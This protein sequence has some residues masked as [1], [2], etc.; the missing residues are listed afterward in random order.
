MQ[1]TNR[2]I[3]VPGIALFGVII[4]VVVSSMVRVVPP[5]RY[6]VLLPL[7]L[8]GVVF[9]YALAWYRVP[10]FLAHSI[11]LWCGLLAALIGATTALATSS[12][13]V[14]SR[15]S[16]YWKL[17]R[18][19][20]SSLFD[21]NSTEVDRGELLV[22]LGVVCWLVAYCSTWILYRR[23]WFW[24]AIA[25]P[26][27]VLLTSL[28]FDDQ[29]GTWRLAIFLFASICLAARN[30]LSTWGHGWQRNRVPVANGLVSRLTIACMPL[31]AVAVLLAVM[32][33]PGVHRLVEVRGG[34]FLDSTWS[35]MRTS[36]LDHYPG[37][38]PAAGNYASFGDQ[39]QIGGH[40]NLSD[41][42]IA[43]VDSD[44]PHYLAARRYDTY[45]GRSWSTDVSAT[46]RMPGDP[47]D[48]S[49]TKVIFAGGQR[50]VL[51]PD[52][53]GA[54]VPETASITVTVPQDD[55]VFTIET[56]ASSTAQV[57]AAMG[58]Q[59]VSS[60]YDV[61]DVELG[62]IPV[63]LQQLIR[64][65]RG[66]DF[67]V[68]ADTGAIELTDPAIASGFDDAQQRLKAY[69]ITAQLREGPDG[70]LIMDV[71]GRIP[72]YDDVEALFTKSAGKDLSDYRVIGLA[73]A[74]TGEQ[75]DSAGTD[76][77]GW[78]K[79]RYLQLSPTITARTDNLALKIVG[80]AGA[81]TPF[82]MAL[83]VQTYLRQNY[84]YELNS[85]QPGDGQ[86]LVDYFLFDH[87]AGRC[88][89]FA[90]S[91]VIMLRSLGIP[92]RAV[93]GF[94]YGSGPVDGHYVYRMN[95]AHLWVEAYFPGLGWVPFEPTPSQATFTYDNSQAQTSL[96]PE[97]AASA[98]ADQPSPA[99]TEEPIDDT[100]PT[101]VASPVPQS[102][103]TGNPGGGSGAA[104]LIWLT[105]AIIGFF[106]ALTLGLFAVS[107]QWQT[108]GYSRTGSLY[109]HLQRVGQWFGLRPTVSTTPAEY[110]ASFG[111][112]F[113]ASEWAARSIT[114][115]YYAEQF[116]GEAE[117]V[118]TIGNAERGWAHIGAI[119][120]GSD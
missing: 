5:D 27:V 92:A 65:V 96:T 101:A 34:S 12:E 47:A 84:G 76:Y 93:G 49:V 119:C 20:I 19:V 70:Q 38:A 91:M 98:V 64:S 24:M 68:D 60:S 55:I 3:D 37:H 45:D 69:P 29:R 61:N 89:Q 4:A 48:I 6:A 78:V 52:V 80:D 107:W 79:S 14:H 31:A 2:Q 73:S 112:R 71:S 88:E 23:R 33:A 41:A 103:D 26:A 111:R 100:L 39:F 86:D 28:R 77:P 62:S 51:S 42:V 56:F 30:T 63:D 115:A 120:S 54:R 40:L 114:D 102:L 106:G 50:V 105:V 66:A 13:I 81:S 7:G 117:V 21:R 59:Q 74:A 82:A 94:N 67:T 8:L 108:R 11:A 46:F 104:G 113:P 118:P 17:T 10:D 97:P 87:Q 15:G 1:P 9:G 57:Y 44:Q 22:A 110:A 18:Q 43:T 32:F 58:W 83:A 25:A 53:T 95:Q 85:P 16:I 75:L 116:G 99:P 109:H 35:T 36:I 72:N 90:T